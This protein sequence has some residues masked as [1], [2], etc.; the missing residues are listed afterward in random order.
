[1]GGGV[2]YFLPRRLPAGFYN[3]TFLGPNAAWKRLYEPNIRAMAGLGRA[4]TLPDPDRYAQRYAHCDVLVVGSGPAGLAAALA[5]AASGAR[6]ILCDEQAEFGGSLLA[7]DEA[8]IEGGS[9]EAFRTASL[10]TLAAAPRVRLLARTTAFGYFP[11]N[12]IG[13]AERIT[14]HLAAPDPRLP[15]ERLWQVRAREVVLATGAHER[16]LVFPENDRPGIMLAEAAR[17]YLARYGV[18]PG[19]RAVLATAHDGA[20]RTA[21]ALHRAGVEIAAIADLRA[22]ADGAWPSAAREAGLPVRL[23]TTIIGTTGRRR[24]ARVDLAARDADGRCGPVE[25]VPCDLL[26]MSGGFTPS[27]HLFSQSR[28]RL[29]FDDASQAFLPDAPAERT[30][31]AGAC[32]GRVELAG[33]LADGYAAGAAAAQAAGCNRAP[34]S[35]HFPVAAREIQPAG[36]LGALPGKRPGAR[37]FVDFQNDVTAKDLALATRE[38]FRS[39]EHIKRYTTTGM[40]TDQ[41]KS[42]N[43]NALGIVADALGSPIPAI[44]LTTFRMPYTPTSFGIFAGA[45]R[46]DLFEPLR[47]TP[48]HAQAMALGAVFEDVGQWKRAR[49][50][51]RA[52]EDMAAAVAR[53]CRAVRSASGLFDA[54]TLGKIE[55]VG[56][57]AATFLERLYVNAWHRLAPGRCR[58][59]LLLRE[60]GFIFDDGV[61]GR[62]AADRFHV[63]T[64]TS[65]IGRV[66]AMM[67]DYRQTEW[68]ELDVWLTATTE[69]WAV[70][71]LQGPRA[72]A[73][74]APLVEAV[75]LAAMPHM[76]LA[77]G[78]IA[79][80]P[81]RLFR[82]SFT[83]E[84]GFEVNV[85][86]SAG[87]AV[88]EAIMAAGA[89]HGLTPYGTEAMHVLRAEKGYLVIGQDTDGTVSPEDA[90]LGRM[91]ARGKPD[92]IGKRA[93]EAMAAR[94][95]GGRKQ[96]VGLLSETPAQVLEE[97]AQIVAE[98]DGAR[99][100]HVTSAYDSPTLGR[101]IALAMVQDGR[102]RLGER[103]RVARPEA[104]PREGHA[105]RV[106]A[107]V[108]YDPEG[109]RLDG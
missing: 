55:I 84:A 65:G 9:A 101:A 80:V 18:R 33:V 98:A 25:P 95:A 92:F 79:G 68:P 17:V 78:R 75:D 27:V 50:F 45:A 52:G 7:E 54:S 90:G 96:L 102:V 37:A 87:A 103:L 67:E 59:G 91:V 106:V 77:E 10:A 86:A 97:G 66:L 35:R 56:P 76:S 11:H 38:G 8:M 64:T 71:A 15:R 43:M 42:S 93:L 105:V 60:D 41:G 108:F 21:L 47:T 58:Y 32:R 26:L 40:A 20:Y 29:R 22:A 3:K 46:G 70:L 107:P 82:V 104:P 12:M 72:R 49:Y 30:H 53:E 31:V 24:V 2:N 81:L 5:A 23:S 100:G 88:W 6:V 69:Q 109:A 62:L 1:V 19:R 36:M 73:I 99:L 39:I 14:D 16:P 89:P 13:L 57:D 48:M 74:L 44:G 4:P 63:T 28:G 85:P 83:G 61:I 94:P 51:P 34:P